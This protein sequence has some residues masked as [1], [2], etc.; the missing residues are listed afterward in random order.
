MQNL[1][2][3]ERKLT[4]GSV[5]HAVRFDATH[6]NNTL[7]RVTIEC[8]NEKAAFELFETLTRNVAYAETDETGV[9][10]KAVA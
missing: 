10:A 7:C 2:V 8:L 1:R 5:V 4:D 9:S 6:E 3:S